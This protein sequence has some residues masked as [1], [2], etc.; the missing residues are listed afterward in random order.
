MFTK[1]SVTGKGEGLPPFLL[2]HAEHEPFVSA[3]EAEGDGVGRGR[4]AADVC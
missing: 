3:G 2:I 1:V 4:A